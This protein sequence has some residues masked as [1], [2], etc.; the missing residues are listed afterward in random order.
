M[1]REQWPSK[2]RVVHYDPGNT[3]CYAATVAGI[4]ASGN[5]WDEG[6]VNLGNILDSTGQPLATMPQRQGDATGEGWALDVP[7]RVGPPARNGEPSWHWPEF[8]GPQAEA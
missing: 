4:G 1:N 8:V 7:Q 6:F 5:T 3:E 2:G